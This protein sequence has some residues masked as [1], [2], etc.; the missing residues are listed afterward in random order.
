[1][2]GVLSKTWMREIV[3]Q[4]TGTAIGGLK[5]EIQSLKK[6][7]KNLKAPNDVEGQIKRGESRQC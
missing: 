2:N 3:E 4:Y 5:E 6:L 7:I 1:M